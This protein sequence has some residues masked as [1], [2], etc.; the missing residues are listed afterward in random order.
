[1]KNKLLSFIHYMADGETIRCMIYLAMGLGYS[2]VIALLNVAWGGS[3]ILVQ[4]LG[5][6][7]AFA[8]ALAIFGIIANIAISIYHWHKNRL[9]VS[10][11]NEKEME[12]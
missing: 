7:I 9:V 10:H 11:L 3:L 4:I 5:G 1:M 6:I 12:K 2:L 8:A